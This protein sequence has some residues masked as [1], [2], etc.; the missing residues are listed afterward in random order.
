[1]SQ[2]LCKREGLSHCAMEGPA[3]LKIDPQ[4]SRGCHLGEWLHEGGKGLSPG[5]S[6][7]PPG[8]P[9]PLL[10]DHSL[11]DKANKITGQE[12]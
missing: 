11:M 1:M 8:G 5:R 10:P 6:P 3:L 4:R 12:L 2:V 7:L 9:A